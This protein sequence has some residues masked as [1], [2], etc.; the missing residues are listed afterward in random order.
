MASLDI[1]NDIDESFSIE[2]HTVDS[3]E[4]CNIILNVSKDKF[5]VLTYNIRSYQ[6]NFDDFKVAL[7]RL[8]S[9]IDVIVLTE[10]WLSEGTIL[11]EMPGYYIY[12]TFSQVNKNGA[13]KAP[14]GFPNIA[15]PP[16]TMVV[17]V[18]HTA[19]LPCQAT[20]NPSPKVRWLW[21]SLPLDVASNPRYALLNDKMH[22]TLQIVK[23]EEE[24]HGKF[25][26]VAENSIGTEFS[27]P[28]VLYVKGTIEI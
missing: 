21:N 28:T 6:K 14:P 13:D 5:T 18:G 19:T 11:E 1:A 9:N 25:E 23:S 2:C 16:T 27:K 26:C 12:R 20:G 17:E 24:D 10:C 22:G 3:P 15:P 7:Y 4:S 8:N